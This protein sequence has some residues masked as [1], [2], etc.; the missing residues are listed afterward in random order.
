MGY[1][2][3]REAYDQALKQAKQQSDRSVNRILSEEED[4]QQENQRVSISP[5][6]V[7]Q[8][9]DHQQES[10]HV[11]VPHRIMI[12]QEQDHAPHSPEHQLNEF[13]GKVNT[14]YHTFITRIDT[15]NWLKLMNDDVMWNLN[16]QSSVNERMLNFLESHPYLPR[17][18]WQL[19]EGSF[20]WKEKALADRE[21]FS[22]RYPNVF[23]Y[24]LEDQQYVT[25]LRYSFL[26]DAGNIDYDA[27]LHYRVMALRALKDHDLQ[28][29]EDMLNKA[30]EVF[31][32]DP[33]LLRLQG[34]FYFR[35][36]DLS[37]ALMAFDHCIRIAPDDTDSYFYRA[38]IYYKQ[39]K[40]VDAIQDLIYLLSQMPE[41]LDMLSLLGKC[42]INLGQLNHA[43]ETYNRILDIHSN[44]IEALVYL[45][46]FEGSTIYQ[47]SFGQSEELEPT[48]ELELQR[49]AV[50]PLLSIFAKIKELIFQLAKN[51]WLYLLLLVADFGLVVLVLDGPLPD[52]GVIMVT[53]IVTILVLALGSLI[54]TII[55][56]VCSVLINY[57]GSK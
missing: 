22:E 38:R 2:R 36:D 15:D 12:L 4:E 47:E 41:N 18:V 19:L 21:L 1:Q 7:M 56:R 9:V 44:D 53:I 6:I 54:L 17:S 45:A 14:I 30:C 52:M 55:W 11:S 8:G 31:P 42:Y 57:F 23:T 46:D 5:R 48:D 37:R 50:P 40:L 13:M 10:Q 32:S 3:L 16:L 35:T 24:A 27:F 39:D 33:D 49:S 51:T 26:A 29:A 28:T 20:R 25:S 43:R 34:E